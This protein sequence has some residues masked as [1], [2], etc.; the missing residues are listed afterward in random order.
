MMLLKAAKE[1]LY[2]VF[3]YFIY[4]TWTQ[5]IEEKQYQKAA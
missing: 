3:K 2:A 4:F 1:T 5:K